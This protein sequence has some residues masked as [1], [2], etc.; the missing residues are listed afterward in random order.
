MRNFLIFSFLINFN[1]FGQ[2]T[3]GDKEIES[4]SKSSD[5][6]KYERDTFLDIYSKV[7]LRKKNCGFTRFPEEYTQDFKQGSN[8]LELKKYYD[9]K[10]EVKGLKNS[11]SPED[12]G[13][14]VGRRKEYQ[15]SQIG[16]QKMQDAILQRVPF[17]KIRNKKLKELLQGNP[18]GFEKHILNAKDDAFSIGFFHEHEDVK[19]ALRQVKIEF[20]E[21]MEKLPIATDH[22]FAFA[23]G[24]EKDAAR[25]RKLYPSR[26]ND[27]KKMK[28]D[29]EV[30]ELSKK[31]DE[32][33]LDEAIKNYKEYKKSRNLT[34]VFEGTGQ[35][36]PKLERNLKL[37]QTKLG[38]NPTQDQ[39]VKATNKALEIS[40]DKAYVLSQGGNSTWSG[41]IRGP[42]AQ[43]LYANKKGESNYRNSQWL[44]LPSEQ[45]NTLANDLDTLTG[46]R[47]MPRKEAYSRALQCLTQYL[48]LNPDANL[49][50]IGHSSGVKA[51]IDFA[52]HLKKKGIKKNVDMLGIDPVDNM[53]KGG[54]EGAL[55]GAFAK[56]GKVSLSITPECWLTDQDRF[57]LKQ[58]Y[59]GVIVSKERDALYKPSNASSFVTYYQK[60][61]RVGLGKNAIQFGIHGSPVKGAENNFIRFNDEHDQHHGMIT[62]DERV[63]S[64][65][66][67]TLVR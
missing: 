30:M 17:D 56:M 26:K 20:R 36:S 8:F 62:L 13:E 39:I 44:Y 5:L 49:S 67:R 41:T 9:L 65:F 60:Q 43:G 58:D 19:D 33:E 61:D 53:M 28:E 22:F 31:Y 47:M 23:E 3:I 15:S 25:S 38:M 63:I 11:L 37:I 35:Y 52:E 10:R 54:L 50:I 1:A 7:G 16:I 66:R 14:Y 27:L 24:V 34:I 42:I 2:D 64:D 45:D 59:V 12:N 29:K 57:D 18:K 46:E 21:E 32:Y 48:K 6:D 51:A 4:I 40:G 55:S